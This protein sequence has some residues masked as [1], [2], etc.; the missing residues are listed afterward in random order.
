MF[1][2]RKGQSTL[3]YAIIITMV[4][5]AFMFMRIY[6]KRAVEG[7]LRDSADDIG[8]Q[9]ESLKTS[10]LTTTTNVGTTIQDQTDGLTQ[11][12]TTDDKSTRMT[13]ED[14]VVW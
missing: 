12:H 9:F 14:V 11:T 2:N 8:D 4:V 5:A 3:E 6:M 1:F 13:S 7:K 10:S